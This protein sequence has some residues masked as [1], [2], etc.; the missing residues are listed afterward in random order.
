MQ[1]L[2]RTGQRQGG[3]LREMRLPPSEWNR[4]LPRVRRKNI[5]E[6]RGLYQV[7][8]SAPHIVRRLY[9]FSGEYQ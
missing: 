3:N 8:V 4:I 1:E 7:R 2:W 6:T 5:R 9:G